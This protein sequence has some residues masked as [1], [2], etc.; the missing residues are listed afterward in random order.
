MEVR[1]KDWEVIGCGNSEV[2]V[3]NLDEFMLVFRSH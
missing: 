1:E 2:R 3:R